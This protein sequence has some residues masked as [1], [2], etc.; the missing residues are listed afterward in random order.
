MIVNIISTLTLLTYFYHVRLKWIPTSRPLMDQCE[1]WQ[2]D[3]F[4]ACVRNATIPN[5]ITGNCFPY[6]TQAECEEG[7]LLFLDEMNQCLTKCRIQEN[8]GKTCMTGQL[9]FNDSCVDLLDIE[10]D[11]VWERRLEA[12]IF[13]NVGYSCNRDHFV[14]WD[15]VCYPLLSPAEVCP[16]GHQIRWWL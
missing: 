14:L 15:D 12:D 6:G 9:S 13:G 2:T 10:D 3:M 11:G 8:D 1:G 4:T 5:M 16:S 7:E